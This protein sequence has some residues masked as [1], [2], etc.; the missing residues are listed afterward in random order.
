MIGQ[1]PLSRA[2]DLFGELGE[3]HGRR[4]AQATVCPGDH[5]HLA[6]QPVVV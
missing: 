5:A 4:S 1:R 2:G 6:I 3:L